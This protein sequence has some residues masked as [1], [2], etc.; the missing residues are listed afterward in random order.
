MKLKKKVRL[1]LDDNSKVEGVYVG[2]GAR[3]GTDVHVLQNGSTLSHIE[4][5]RVEKEE[6]VADAD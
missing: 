3:L 2:R 6:E 5:H 1:H 4:V